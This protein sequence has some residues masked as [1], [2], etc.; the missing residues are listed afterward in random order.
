MLVLH[1]RSRQV[2]VADEHL[3]GTDMIVELFG[4]RQR[5]AHQ[6]GFGARIVQRDLMLA[7]L[8]VREF[9]ASS[10]TRSHVLLYSR[11]QSA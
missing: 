5:T 11:S 2:V 4:E 3:D 7:V 1:R 6:T 10:D 9:Q 8:T